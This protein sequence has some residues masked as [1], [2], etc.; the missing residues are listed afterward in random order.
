MAVRTLHG[1]VRHMPASAF[2]L[3]VAIGFSACGPRLANRNID[4]LNRQYDSAE[5][6]G[7][8]L[9][10]KEVEAVLG[11]PTHVEPFPIEMQTTKELQGVRYY[12]EEDGQVVVLHFI[13]NKLIRRAGR[14]GDKLPED[15][16]MRQMPSKPEN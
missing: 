1:I 5:K 12:Y 7:K 9:S 6:A 11:Q 13:D 3:I 15:P 14:F 10:I 2:S 8:G 16:E 4:A